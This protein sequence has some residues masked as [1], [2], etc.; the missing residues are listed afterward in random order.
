MICWQPTIMEYAK[1][2]RQSYQIHRMLP[3]I[4]CYYA[5]KAICLAARELTTPH[6]PKRSWLLPHLQVKNF[7]SKTFQKSR[8]LKHVNFIW[9][10]ITRLW[11]WEAIPVNLEPQ[12]V[13]SSVTGICWIIDKKFY[14][15]M[16]FNQFCS[17]LFLNFTWNKWWP[18]YRWRM[19]TKYNIPYIVHNVWEYK[20]LWYGLL[21]VAF[22]LFKQ[23]WKLYFIKYKAPYLALQD[24]EPVYGLSE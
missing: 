14:S 1:R 5:S 23:L 11:F 12:M 10:P 19:A 22:L 2:K 3:S 21:V 18:D 17:V 9:I 6:S 16:R 4:R 24:V 7:K 15:Q 8:R 20:I 13:E